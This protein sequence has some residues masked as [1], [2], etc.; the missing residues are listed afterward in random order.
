MPRALCSSNL[1]EHAI[2]V[3]N[4]YEYQKMDT[5][6]YRTSTSANFP[7]ELE[8][9]SNSSMFV[10]TLVFLEYRSGHYYRLELFLIRISFLELEGIYLVIWR[11]FQSQC[12]EQNPFQWPSLLILVISNISTVLYGLKKNYKIQTFDLKHQ[13]TADFSLGRFFIE[14]SLKAYSKVW[15]TNHILRHMTP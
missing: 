15:P 8:R 12:I 2:W 11:L 14:W 7:S 6:E 3:S 1:S 9:V 5:F 13:K 10:A 4:E